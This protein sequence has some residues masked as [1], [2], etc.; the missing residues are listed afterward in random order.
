MADLGNRIV[1]THFLLRRFY[2]K[3]GF[4]TDRRWG[5]LV[6]DLVP[7]PVEDPEVDGPA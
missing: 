5:G 3:R 4:R 1:K 7:E 2:L 6:R